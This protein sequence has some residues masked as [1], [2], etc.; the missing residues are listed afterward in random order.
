[1]PTPAAL[2][3]DVLVHAKTAGDVHPVL[4]QDPSIGRIWSLAAVV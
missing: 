1:M 4:N 2:P 3:L